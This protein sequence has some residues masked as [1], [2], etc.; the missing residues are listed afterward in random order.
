M[1]L[2]ELVKARKSIRK[3]KDIDIS[4]ELLTS[5]FNVVRWAP[6]SNNIQPWL[7]I[8]IRDLDIKKK[9]ATASQNQKFIY[10]AP[11]V[12]VACGLIDDSKD[13][14]GN[15]MVSYPVDVAI[16]MTYLILAAHEKG[17][18]TCWIGSFNEEKIRNILNLPSNLKVVAI[19][20]L[21]YPAESPNQTERKD[22]SS[23]LK[24]EK[25]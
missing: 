7:F 6:S 12:I 13:V 10:E 16:A 21:G 20:P 2:L 4:N 22:I 25:V 23:I 19:T 14:I 15:Y 17:L 1:S 11:V 8:A 18:G 9:I 5:I 24:F 3:Y